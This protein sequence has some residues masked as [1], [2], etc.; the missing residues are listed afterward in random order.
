MHNSV[1]SLFLCPVTRDGEQEAEQ[2][3]FIIPAVFILHPTDSC[4]S[5]AFLL[6]SHFFI[7]SFPPHP[8]SY[9]HI[10][11]IIWIQKCGLLSYFV[12]PSFPRPCPVFTSHSSRGSRS[13]P[14]SFLFFLPFYFLR[15][16]GEVRSW[17]AWTL[18]FPLSG[19]LTKPRT[20]LSSDPCLPLFI[21]LF[22]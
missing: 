7:L 11:D 18:S 21:N 6:S 22:F 2:G 16:T 3:D 19:F 5:H 20:Y 15:V 14:S 1:V 4:T 9:T 17:R 12:F 13:I 8:I 10:S